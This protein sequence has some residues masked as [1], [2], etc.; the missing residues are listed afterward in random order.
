MATQITPTTELQAVNTMLSV[1]GEAPV[2]SITGTTTVDVSVAKNIL[3]E[4]SLSIQSQGWNFNTN[5]EYKSLSLDT[6]NKIPLPTNCVKIDANKSNRHLNLT[7]R[8]GFL[9]DMEKDTDIFTSVPNSVDIVLVQQFEHLPEY[10]RRYITMKAARRFASRFIGDTTITQLIGQDE[11][12]ALVVTNTYITAVTAGAERLRITGIGSV[13]IGTAVPTNFV[14]IMKGSDHQNIVIVRGADDISEYAGVGVYDG[15]AVFTGGGV[16]VTTTGIVFRTSNGG[17][18]TERVYITGE[19][20]VGIGTEIPKSHLEV[21]GSAAVLTITDTRNQSFSVGDVLSSLAFDTD[22]AS[23]G[24]G[25]ASHPRAKINLVT[26]NTFGSATGLSFATKADTSNAPVEKLRIKST[27]EIGIG[28]DDPSKLLELSA[29]NPTINVKATANN[30]ASLEFIES[31]SAN[32]GSTGTNGFRLR[33]DGGD[34]RFYIASGANA[35]VNNVVS[36]DRDTGAFG[37]GLD[38]PTARLQVNGTSNGLQARF[39]GVGTGLGV[40]CFQKTNN[41]AGVKFIAQDSTYGTFS[42]ETAGSERLRI[43]SDGQIGI[44]KTSPKAWNTSYTSLQIQDAGYIVGST[45]DSFVAIGANNYLATDGNYKYT[46]TDHTSQLYQV[47]GTLV[48]RNAGAAGN[49][50]CLLYTSPS[51]RDRQKSRMPSSA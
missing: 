42:F 20:K 39:G 11:N 31:T 22:D 27:G 30:D 46:N 36:I 43:T 21:S 18:E 13:G 51:P 15:N 10:A 49:D 44:N 17:V 37:L 32:F 2:N 29:A 48:F 19:G 38:A 6:N 35:T 25:S 23:G 26:E 1:I 33:Y 4:T 16:G 9:Y 12:E 7:I 40:S 41:N 28:T 5:Y 24:A 47:D 8:N 3:D 14:D 50:S 34:N 45:D